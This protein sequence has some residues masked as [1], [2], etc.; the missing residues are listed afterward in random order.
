G[1][2]EK[3]SGKHHEYATWKDKL[4]THVAQFQLEAENKLLEAGD[5]DPKVCMRDFLESTPPCLTDADVKAAPPEG[6]LAVREEIM[7]WRK[8]DAAMRHVLN[9]TLPNSFLSSLPDEVQNMEVRLIWQHL[10]RKFTNGD[11][12]GLV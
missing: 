3:F 2:L 5:P 1:G 6:Q 4:L 11:A 9:S 12:G 10:E 8:A 7:V